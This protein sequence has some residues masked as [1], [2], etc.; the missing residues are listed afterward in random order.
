[1]FKSLKI[2]GLAF[3]RSTGQLTEPEVGRPMC[4]NVHSKGRSTVCAQQGPVDR[5]VDRQRVSALC[6]WPRSTGRSTAGH[7]PVYGRPAGRPQFLTVGNPTVG[8]RPGGRPTAGRPAELAS[9]S[10]ILGAYKRGFPWTVF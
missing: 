9:N 5:T 8:G 3:C 2:V 7:L 4:T 6:K 1:M 10:H